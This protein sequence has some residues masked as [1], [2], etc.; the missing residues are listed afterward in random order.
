[1]LFGDMILTQDQV[2][3][4]LMNYANEGNEWAGMESWVKDSVH[5][6]PMGIVPFKKDSTL[7]KLYI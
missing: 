4:K 6:W 1:M 3:N 7:S 2:Q 5:K